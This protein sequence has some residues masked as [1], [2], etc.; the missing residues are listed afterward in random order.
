MHETL[1][2]HTVLSRLG[3][4]PIR[5]RLGE[6]PQDFVERLPGD[7]RRRLER[8][9]REEWDGKVVNVVAD[10]DVMVC[11]KGRNGDGINLSLPV[12]WLRPS[13]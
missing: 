13:L 7:I 1:D 2:F 5:V 12:G 10:P 3:K 4:G 8:A 9:R 6:I 11:L